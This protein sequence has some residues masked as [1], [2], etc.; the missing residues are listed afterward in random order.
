M[1][2]EDISVRLRKRSG[3]EAIDLGYAM[4]IAWRRDIFP[5]WAS[6][7]LA[8]AVLINLICFAKPLV[9]TFV[10]WWLKPA[11]D[12]VILHVLAGAAFGAA[13][14]MAATW[15]ALPRLLTGSGMFA[16]LTWRRFDGARSFSLPISQL[17]K[18]SGKAAASRRTVL[19]REGRGTAVWLTIISAHFEV[20]LV[21]SIYAFAE[22]FL[23]GNAGSINPF[24]WIVESPPDW[25][26]WLSNFFSVCVV[27]LLEPFYVAAGFALYLNTRTTLEGWDIELAFKRMSE[28]LRAARRLAAQSAAWRAGGREVRHVGG[29][30]T[31]PGVVLVLAGFLAAVSPPEASAQVPS[32]QAAVAPSP[33]ADPDIAPASAPAAVPPAA[34]TTTASVGTPSTG[35][36]QQA[37]Q[38]LSDPIF[39]ETR[40]TWSLKYVGPG[41]DRKPS[42]PLRWDWLER[43][44]EWLA[45]GLRALA[46]GLGAVVIV[47]L[48]Y[49]LIRKFEKRDWQRRRV[50]PD[51]LFG[52]DVR[53]DS[54]PDD[55]PGAAAQ[56]LSRGDVRLALSLLYRAALVS[57]IADGRFEIAPGDTE[58]TCAAHVARHY[59]GAASAKPEYFRGLVATW[60]RVAYARQTVSGDEV[61]QLIAAWSAHFSLAG[62]QAQRI[63]ERA[64]S[65]TVGALT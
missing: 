11:F 46:W 12:R 42:K 14:G 39:G 26:Q 1:R 4:T 23:P 58:G 27:L 50:M 54:L 55:V 45:Y 13:P 43:F 31:S 3:F 17:E 34:P 63:G 38:I 18:Q 8:A 40:E 10:I 47:G 35:A 21:L 15:R 24:R 29:I 33:A 36:A 32:P 16:A 59:G 48:L 49:L 44:G 2:L 19:G 56:A 52:L 51:M 60:Q 25:L 41:S 9:A 62:R 22:M 61:E 5:V 65:G 6:V 20:L 53:P 57:L 30:G 37:K 64:A 28:R 7:Y